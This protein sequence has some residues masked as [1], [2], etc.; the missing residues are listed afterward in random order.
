MLSQRRG[1]YQSYKNSPYVCLADV[2]DIYGDAT[3]AADI[4]HFEQY[5][6]G[7]YTTWLDH[8]A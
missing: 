4:G 7:T 2:C 6:N 5:Y 3:V 8:Y 1:L